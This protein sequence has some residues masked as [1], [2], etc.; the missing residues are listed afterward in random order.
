MKLDLDRSENAVSVTVDD[1]PI[2]YSRDLGGLRFMYYDADENVIRYEFH[3]ISSGV[4]VHDLPH[5]EVLG[6]LLREQ[7]IRVLD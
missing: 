3:D 7:G 2:Y 6:R 4:D 5:R 1:Q